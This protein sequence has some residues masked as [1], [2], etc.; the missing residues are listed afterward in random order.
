MYDN[1]NCMA[2][3]EDNSNNNFF[4][5][6]VMMLGFMLFFNYF[7][8][9]GVNQPKSVMTA[10]NHD[11]DENDEKKLI[12]VEDAMK[13]ASRISLTNRYID[14][15]IDLNGCIIDSVI[16]KKYKESLDDDKNVMLLTP[17]NTEH[18]FFYNVA[19][20]CD[21]NI[22]VGT[23]TCWEIKS[24]NDNTVILLCKINEN[25]CIERTIYLD[26]KYLINISDKIINSDK[27][28][29]LVS[30]A[31]LQKINPLIKDYAVVHEGVVGISTE[32][33]V[34]EVKYAKLLD[35]EKFIAGQW[36]GFTDMYWL[37]SHINCSKSAK[38]LCYNN[39]N[40]Y[41]CRLRDKF[42]A[43]SNSVTHMEYKIFVGPKNLELLNEYK[44]QKS[45][46][47]FDMAIDFGWFFMITKPL[48]YLLEFLASIFSNMGV[49]I[50]VLTLLLKILTL[51]L[52][53]KSFTSA[54]KMKKLQP[55]I[56]NL[57]KMYA[58][59]KQ[60]MN[61]ELMQLYKKEGV[62]PLSGCLPMLLQA[63]IFFCL[64]KVF[65]ISI[66]MRQANFVGWIHDLSAPD[67]LYLFN[68]FGIINWTPPSFLQIGVW[69]LIMG[70]TMFLQQKLTSKS[71]GAKTQEAKIQ[72]NMMYAMPII[73]TYICAS[74]P[75]GVVIYWTISNIISIAQ[76]FYANKTISIN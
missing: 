33:S 25:I 75:V 76:Q 63:P 37:S 57:Q 23:N 48:L 8:D 56:A 61:I 58:Y 38:I 62:S 52:T 15:S 5:F 13:N 45:I 7:F 42:S 2:F 54:A 16:L 3:N 36:C 65:F 66:S 72:E 29:K 27:G 4:L 11:E 67:P 12:S 71:S 14:V 55:K 50:I 17:K 10:E 28:I 43:A 49:V 74:F 70:I 68:L 73:F 24:Q 46:A 6:V 30:F 53:K 60:K 20:F 64:Y 47:K 1:C 40:T 21:K 35:G 31:D 41:H 69:P 32:G 51:P 59:D 19:Y 26:S 22:L 9:S 18:E 39:N 34:T 44:N